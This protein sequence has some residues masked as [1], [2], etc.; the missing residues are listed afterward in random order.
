MFLTLAGIGTLLLALW[1]LIA[2]EVRDLKGWKRAFFKILPTSL[3]ALTALIGALQTRLPSSFCLFAGLA[4]CALADWQLE[5]RFLLGMGCF[6]V[7]H[8]CYC[9][10]YLL[11][12]PLR[13]VSLLVFLL[14]MCLVL[15]LYSRLKG[16]L[17]KAPLFLCYAVVLVSM[18]SLAAGRGPLLLSGALLFV[19]SDLMIGIRMAK[20][21]ENRAWNITIMV[22]YYLAQWLIAMT[23]WFPG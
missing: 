17:D 1:Y 23:A 18:A 13:I 16:G 4:V 19:L 10:G 8:L 5:F 21:I 14:L 11:A 20:N 15:I 22:T 3:C 6:A 2:A 7:G 12:G 9:A